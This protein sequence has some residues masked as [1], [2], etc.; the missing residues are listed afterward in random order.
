MNQTVRLPVFAYGTLRP[1][2]GNYAWALAGKTT[3]EV[4]ATVVGMV[5]LDG[6][7]FPFTVVMGRSAYPAARV[8][9]RPVIAGPV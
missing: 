3:A 6:P 4:P 5:L 1:G 2:E 8:R 7:G 9:R